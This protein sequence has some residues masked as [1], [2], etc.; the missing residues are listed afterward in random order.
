[1]E[2]TL[3]AA[4]LTGMAAL[5]VVL[6]LSGAG[7]QFD[8]TVTATVVGLFTGRLVAMVLSGVNPIA[9]PLDVLLVRG[10]VDT[11][12][13]TAG[14]LAYLAGRH[15]SHLPALATLSPAALAGLAGWHA[16]CL[17]RGTCL[18]AA[19]D[20]PWGWTLAG[21]EVVRHP[22]EL[23]AAALLVAAAWAVAKYP[24]RGGAGMA[25]AAA[26]CARLITEPLRPALGGNTA[27]WYAAGVAAGVAW[28][29]MERLRAPAPASRS[30]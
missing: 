22:V 2:F 7:S 8:V 24:G 3:L 9:H 19:G 27:W 26:A 12:G 15:R 6:R 21:S 29:L 4:A 16:G 14:A 28:M 5:W 18:G 23:Y 1:M 17:W 11:V 10:G 20:I 30:G 25:L 13:A